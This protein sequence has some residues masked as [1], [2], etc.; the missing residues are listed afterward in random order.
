MISLAR[1]ILYLV[2]LKGLIIALFP[3]AVIEAVNVIRNIKPP[4]KR[5]IGGAYVILGCLLFYLTRVYL[6]TLL[7]HWIIVIMGAFLM[8]GGLFILILP[9][10]WVRFLEWYYQ[11]SPSRILGLVFIVFSISLLILLSM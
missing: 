6:E 3:S 11:K 7:V 5:L 4:V 8:T 1:I 10:L 9:G 2:I